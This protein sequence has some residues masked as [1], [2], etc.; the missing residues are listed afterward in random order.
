MCAKQGRRHSELC[1]GHPAVRLGMLW[2]NKLML[3]FESNIIPQCN[4]RLFVGAC[5]LHRAAPCRKSVMQK[6][7]I[8]VRQLSE[9]H[10]VGLAVNACCCLTC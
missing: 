8:C 4:R 3:Q 6:V 7:F 5:L 1:S 2:K 9:L 10:V